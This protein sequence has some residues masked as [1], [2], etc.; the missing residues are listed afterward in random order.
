[1]Q[2]RTIAVL[3][4][5]TMM[6]A[7][8]LGLF[9]KPLESQ[10]NPGTGWRAEYFNNKTLAGSPVLVVTEDQISANWGTTAPYPATG[11][12]IPAD[13]F[14]VRWTA[15]PSFGD[16]GLYRFRV[17]ADDGIRLFIDDILVIDE[18]K[19]AP[20]RVV[21]RDVQLSGGTHRL[22]VEYFEE[23]DLAGAVVSWELANPPAVAPTATPLP[24]SGGGHANGNGSATQR[25]VAH[26]ATG[27]LNVRANPS[28]TAARI[29]QVYLYQS[30]PILGVSADGAWYLI[31]LRD[32][33]S[34]WVA[35][36]YIYRNDTEIGVGVVPGETGSF[37]AA[38]PIEVVGQSTS[39]LKIR[40]SPRTGEQIGVVPNQTNVRILARNSNGAWFYITYEGIEGW[41]YSP[42]IRLTNGRVMDLPIR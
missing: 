10:A 28:V 27:V 39:E 1:M 4:T 14:S 12:G 15:T 18:F 3:L 33:S 2:N 16:G 21:T 40:V 29:A 37:A 9:I 34:G 26:I 24:A 36:R 25:A 22:R 13:G 7:F 23:V 5:A 20:F 17:G 11:A 32:G 19:A 31:E 38:A 35:E 8:V 41:V 42:Y 30:F 6:I